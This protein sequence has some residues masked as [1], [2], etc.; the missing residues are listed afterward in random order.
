MAACLMH[1]LL[2]LQYDISTVLFIGWLTVCNGYKSIEFLMTLFKKNK[3]D[4][5]LM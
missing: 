5:A 4:N 2:Q 3:N 1:L